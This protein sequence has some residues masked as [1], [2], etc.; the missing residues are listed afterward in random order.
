MYIARKSS[1]ECHEKHYFHDDGMRG[2]SISSK[3]LIPKFRV[4]QEFDCGP[5]LSN[6]SQILKTHHRLCFNHCF[7]W[8]ISLLNIISEKYKSFITAARIQSAI[9]KCKMDGL[10]NSAGQSDWKRKHQQNFQGTGASDGFR[11]GNVQQNVNPNLSTG[12]IIA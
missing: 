8:L 11:C 1:K 6:L 12:H 5:V 3:R 7:E 2:F 9:V 10:R 4:P